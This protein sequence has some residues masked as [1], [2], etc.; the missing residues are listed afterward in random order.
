MSIGI[1]GLLSLFSSYIVVGLDVKNVLTFDLKWPKTLAFL[2]VVLGPLIPYF[3]SFKSFIGLVSFV[4]GVFLALEGLF[5]V[6]M[7]VASGRREG[8]SVLLN[9]KSI[10]AI[11]FVGVVFSVALIYEVAKYVQ[12]F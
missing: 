8:P 3:L 1:L 7:W 2:T 12:I 9:K 11:I 4:G 10:L 6:F 5:V